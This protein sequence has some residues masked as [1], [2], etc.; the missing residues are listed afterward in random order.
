MTLLGDAQFETNGNFLPL[1]LRQ[2]D[3]SK[4]HRLETA[5]RPNERN[6]VRFHAGSVPKRSVVGEQD[7][8]DSTLRKLGLPTV[9]I[10]HD[11]LGGSQAVNREF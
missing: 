9:R 5:F 2:H 8:F 6:E 1:D 11:Q 3:V 4:L 7:Y 10:G